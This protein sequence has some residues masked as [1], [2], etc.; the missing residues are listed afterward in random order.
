MSPRIKYE[1]VIKTTATSIITTTATTS[2][3]TTET[4]TTIEERTTINVNV[5]PID[6][7]TKAFDHANEMIIKT[8]LPSLKITN[9]G[10]NQ[11]DLSSK[12]P[13]IPSTMIYSEESITERE[14]IS[15]QSNL[16]YMFTNQENNEE[17]TDL[18]TIR[19]KINEER[20]SMISIVN[21]Q[22]LLSR[23]LSNLSQYITTENPTLESILNDV[24]STIIEDNKSAGI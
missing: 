17:Q 5:E 12:F 14:I 19:T 13:S 16:D 15:T 21:N 23:L 10:S 18:T 24:N 3:T 2:T 20:S 11:D 4:A 1:P 22:S 6:A 8:E 9:D 7:T